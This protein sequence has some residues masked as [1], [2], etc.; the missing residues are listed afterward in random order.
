MCVIALSMALLAAMTVLLILSLALVAL[1]G[2]VA[3]AGL[4]AVGLGRVVEL[5][6]EEV[7]FGCAGG[8]F[9]VLTLWG[10]C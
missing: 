1:L 5:D 9:A 2:A 7:G 4:A 8:D 6:V 3:V 10:V